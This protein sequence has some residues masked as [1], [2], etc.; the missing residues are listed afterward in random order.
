MHPGTGCQ[1]N[2][3]RFFLKS[4]EGMGDKWK[5]ATKTNIIYIL[6][7]IKKILDNSVASMVVRGVFDGFLCC[8]VSRGCNPRGGAV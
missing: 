8:G 3:D 7:S 4:G 6:K 1:D 5:G 2:G